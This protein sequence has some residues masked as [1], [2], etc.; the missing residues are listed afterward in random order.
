MD[1]KVVFKKGDL[2]VVECGI[3]DFMVQ[4]LR[5]WPIR[6]C[7][8]F[9]ININVGNDEISGDNYEKETSVNPPPQ[10]R[11]HS[12]ALSL[13]YAIDVIKKEYGE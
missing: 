3:N 1:D 2:R 6:H 13:Q 10:W 8:D 7:L 9:I 5:G 11:Y 4:R 12:S